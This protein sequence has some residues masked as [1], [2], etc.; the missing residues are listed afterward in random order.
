MKKGTGIVLGIIGSFVLL[1]VIVVG[2]GVS[3]YNGIVRAETTVEEKAST[4]KVDL[5]RRADLIPNLVNTVRGYAAHEEAIFTAITEARAKLGG[6]QTIG[7]QEAANNE[8]TN[9][10]GRLCAIAEDNPELKAN[11]NF[12]NLQTQ[13]EGTENRIGVS[14][15]DYNAAVKEYNLRL[16]R[17]PSSVVAGMFGFE[18]AAMFEGSEGIESTP[19]VSF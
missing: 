6:A 8:I 4:V 16:R 5:Q 2:W 15:K 18:K 3:T 9:A 14:R 10:L 12:I 7:E 17:F 19:E 1:V 13:L 11:Q